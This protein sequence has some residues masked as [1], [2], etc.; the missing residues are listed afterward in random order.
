MNIIFIH[1]HKF[2]LGLNGNYY[3]DG[4]FTNELFDR[5]IFSE[6]D[7][8]IVVSRVLSINEGFSNLNL[9]DHPKVKF[10]SVR[11]I[12][13]IQIFVFNFFYNINIFLKV[14]KSDLNIVRLPSFLGL[15][16]CF[17]CIFFQKKFFVEVVGHA[18]DS[19]L[20]GNSGF[21]KIIFA[22]IYFKLT[23]FV[24][25][26]SAGAIYV[27]K[28]ALQ[29]DFPCLGISEY[30]SNVILKID[31]KFNPKK[32]YSILNTPNIGLIGS[33]NNHYKGIN[34][35]IKTIAFL[36]EKRKLRVDLHILGHGKLLDEYQE[37]AKSLNI[38]DQVFFDGLLPVDQVPG[39]LDKMD[40]YI[41]PSLTEGLPRALIEA[42]SRGL[43][44]LASRTGGIPELLPEHCTFEEFSQEI[45]SNM[46]L[47]I[48][49]SEEL[50]AQLGNKNF[51]QSLNYNFETLELK[52]RSFW[53]K[54]RNIIG[55]D[56]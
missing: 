55:K 1:D 39:W 37:L 21:I 25:K 18:K 20:D 3:T 29:Q 53:K 13:P 33:F 2:R 40:I 32:D 31:K 45:F 19:L 44:C 11:G 4:K 56:I 10:N 38:D 51:V 27:T 28:E 7:S 12:S 14:L 49:E 36:K 42:M 34:F 15:F 41:Q 54:V 22:N 35:A 16:Y 50:R 26:K 52:R 8:V 43:P 47:E 6:S 17:L 9:V 48:L 46:L 23:Q 24:I 5:Y 30:A